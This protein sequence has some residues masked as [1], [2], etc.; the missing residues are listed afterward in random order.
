MGRGAKL[1]DEAIPRL[2]KQT[3]SATAFGITC[4]ASVHSDKLSKRIPG[5]DVQA[6][7]IAGR[8]RFHLPENP[9]WR[10]HGEVTVRSGEC[11]QCLE[12]P[13]DTC[14]WPTFLS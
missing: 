9:S 7:R 2:V 10:C 11:L 12:G 1:S 3:I 8:G 4:F 13:V 5:L 6:H 14:Q